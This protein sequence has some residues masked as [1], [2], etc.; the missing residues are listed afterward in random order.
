MTSLLI[1]FKTSDIVIPVIVFGGIF[2]L[3]VGFVVVA[4]IANANKVKFRA[5]IEPICTWEYPEAEWL[6]YAARY[7]LAK[8]PKGVAR[9]KITPVDI[10]IADDG[11]NRR[12]ELDAMR[13][14]VTGC[15]IENNIFKI[16]ARS[17][18][19]RSRG[20]SRVTYTKLDIHLPIPHGEEQGAAKAVEYFT[21]N[22]AK[23]SEK[24]ASVMP[25]DGS[26]GIFGDTGL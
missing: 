26:V 12:N 13:T 1:F 24:I 10:W 8:V 4:Q 15:R 16:R 14:C 25:E 17:W 19:M 11:W 23:Q 2:L 3:A 5:K 6:D 18:A 21:N 7:D 20:S 9:V 22:I